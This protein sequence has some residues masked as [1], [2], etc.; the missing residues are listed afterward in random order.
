VTNADV[1]ESENHIALFLREMVMVMTP[2]A[3]EDRSR[4]SPQG[5]SDVIFET[6]WRRKCEAFGEQHC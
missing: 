3:F 2:Q 1:L 4:T 5:S 6:Q